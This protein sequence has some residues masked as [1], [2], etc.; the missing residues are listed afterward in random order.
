MTKKTYVILIA[1]TSPFRNYRISMDYRNSL[2]HKSFHN[3]NQI[4]PFMNGQKKPDHINRADITLP[5]L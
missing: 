2:Y 5:Q 4:N 3:Y 1:R